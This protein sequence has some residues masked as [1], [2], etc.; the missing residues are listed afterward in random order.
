MEK[1]QETKS[2]YSQNTGTYIPMPK[3]IP[4]K[5]TMTGQIGDSEALLPIWIT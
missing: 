1:R 3:L 5:L 4:G 2:L